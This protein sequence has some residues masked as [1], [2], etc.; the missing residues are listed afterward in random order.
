MPFY[1]NQLRVLKTGSFKF[2]SLKYKSAAFYSTIAFPYIASPIY[3]FNPLSFARLF[4]LPP[5]TRFGNVYK[6]NERLQAKLKF[7]Q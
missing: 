2:V 1:S 3:F 6:L 4:H 5:A 7:S